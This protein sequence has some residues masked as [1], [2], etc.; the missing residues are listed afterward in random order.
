[1]NA[2]IRKAGFP[3]LVFVRGDDAPG[4][5]EENE[6]TEIR[7]GKR[8][9]P[10]LYTTYEMIAIQKEIGCTAFQLKDQ[11]FGLRQE[12]EDDPTSMRMDVITDGIKTEKLGTLIR[13]LGNAGLEER[14]EE[15]D[16]TDKWIL[17]NMKPVMILPYCVAVLEEIN[18]GNMIEDTKPNEEKGPVDEV[19]EEQ[20]AKKQPG[21]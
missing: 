7:I 4:E 17:R 10:L 19:L 16:L 6:M 13:I 11:V 20:N 12:D 3:L 21:N 5:S 14:G 15:P 8:T 9:V 2:G 1:M 18:A